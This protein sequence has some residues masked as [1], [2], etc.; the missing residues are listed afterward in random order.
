MGSEVLTEVVMQTSVF[1]DITSCSSLE[2]NGLFG[3]TC[4]F[5]VQGH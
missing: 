3:G 2:V 4:C 5:H 1:W